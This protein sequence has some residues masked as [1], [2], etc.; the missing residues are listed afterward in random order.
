M[1]HATLKR[2]LT[3]FLLDDLQD[4]FLIKFLRQTLDSSQSL[5]TITL[6][7]VALVHFKPFSASQPSLGLQD[8]VDRAEVANTYAEFEYECNSETA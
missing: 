7:L 2:R 5:T 8:I 3:K 4:L 1:R 6:Y